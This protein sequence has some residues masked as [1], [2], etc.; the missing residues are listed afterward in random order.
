[1]S[2]SV[3]TVSLDL[4]AFRRRLRLPY[5]SLSKLPT[6]CIQ[7]LLLD[8]VEDC[9][10]VNKIFHSVPTGVNR[11]IEVEIIMKLDLKLEILPWV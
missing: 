7:P 3:E 8:D 6:P 11:H 1:M 5:N 2:T 9:N 10:N 4:E